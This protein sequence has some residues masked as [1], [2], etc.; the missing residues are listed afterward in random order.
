MVA[1]C[2]SLSMY[3]GDD[4]SDIDLYIVTTDQSLWLV[5]T[6]LTFTL[7]ILR[8]R[9]HGV[10]TT[11][12]FC[13]SFF[14]TTSGMDM[15]KIMIPDDIYMQ[16]WV[17]FLRPIYS[18]AGTYSAFVA[19]NKILPTYDATAY[20]L[21]ENIKN[22]PNNMHSRVYTEICDIL[23]YMLDRICYLCFAWVTYLSYIRLGRPWGIVIGPYML[24]FH[25]KDRREEI[26]DVVLQ[27]M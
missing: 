7:H 9:R 3:A 1:V 12:R 2:N 24:K 6:L 23:V 22:T 15:Q 16:H 19:T 20:M 21:A 27:N 11:G 5:R 25:P 14:S 17:H 10:H 4:E 26:R 18:I 13:L 8:V